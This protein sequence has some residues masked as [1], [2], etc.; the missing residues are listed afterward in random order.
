MISKYFISSNILRGICKVKTKQQ[1]WPRCGGFSGQ[2]HHAAGPPLWS[3]LSNGRVTIFSERGWRV[4]SGGTHCSLFPAPQPGQVIQLGEEL[5][6]LGCGRKQGT[7]DTSTHYKLFTTGFASP[8]SSRPH[9]CVFPMVFPVNL[10]WR[11]VNLTMSDPSWE[12]KLVNKL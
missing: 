12:I 5:L 1:L 11:A 3:S 6:L 2:P 9:G 4:R 10:P 7:S 8:G